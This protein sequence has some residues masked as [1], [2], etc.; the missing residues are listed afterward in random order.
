VI[1]VGVPLKYIVAKI[2]TLFCGGIKPLFT[3]AW[4]MKIPMMGNITSFA[5]QTE[6][7]AAI[8]RR[9]IGRGIFILAKKVP[10]STRESGIVI[11]PM[12]AAIGM[13][14]RRPHQS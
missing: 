9:E 14:V 3:I 5:T 12:K 7:I 11:E 6:R 8:G 2:C 13:R 1:E 4:T 10:R